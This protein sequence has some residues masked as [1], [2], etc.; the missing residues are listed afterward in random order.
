MDLGAYSR[1]APGNVAPDGW[2]NERWKNADKKNVASGA[3]RQDTS[4]V[5]VYSNLLCAQAC[6]APEYKI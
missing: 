2:I 6:Q 4:F 3:A 1:S 5:T